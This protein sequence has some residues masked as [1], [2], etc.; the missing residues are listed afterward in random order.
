[1]GLQLEHMGLVILISKFTSI[2]Q[3][4]KEG[5]MT[6]TGFL[7]GI[8][9]NKVLILGIYEPVEKDTI[10]LVTLKG[11]R[12]RKKVLCGELLKIKRLQEVY[13]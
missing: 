3:R 8:K 12:I 7:S 9:V 6:Y 1:M 5:V 4:G 2:G 13:F 10:Y 11:A